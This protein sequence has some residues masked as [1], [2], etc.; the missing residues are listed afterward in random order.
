[1]K[2]SIKIFLFFISVTVLSSCKKYLDLAPISSQA[3][4]N[5][6]K[7]ESDIDQALAGVY[8]VLLT[9]PDVDN[10]YLSECRSSN[11]YIYSVD[12]ARDYYTLAHFQTTSSLDALETSWTMNYRLIERA[13]HILDVID[14][15]SFADTTK[16]SREKAET[17]F[18]RA[19]A[20][21][22]LVKIF[23]PVPLIKTV[24]S[25]T[26]AM[27]YPRVGTDT[28]Y[29]FITS[30]LQAVANTTALPYKYTTAAL[31]GRVNRLAAL[32]L[33]GK[34]YMFMAGYPLQKTANYQNAQT[35]LKQVLDLE[36]TYWNFAPTYGEIFKT[37][38]DNK[39]N[40][41]EVQYISGGK[42]LGSVI[43]GEVVP[44]DMTTSL[45][46]FGYY[47]MAGLTSPSRDL[48]KSYEPGDKRE[49]LTIDT[50]YR[51]KANV[52]VQQDWVRKYLDS[53]VASSISNSSDWPI[54]FPLL[55]TED[56]MLLYAES[57]NEIGGPTA[58]TVAIVNRLRTRAGLAGI[59]P[60]TQAGFRTAIMNERRHEL[61]WEGQ[62]WFDLVRTNTF[63]PV[64]NSFLTAYYPT[65]S[66]AVVQTQYLLP[67]P[68]TEM[69]V[70]PG[71]Y[72]QNAGY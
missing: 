39:Y 37:V 30:E 11:F 62:Y 35:V 54:N 26:D 18:L 38:N 22:D 59:N 23:G 14:N 71:L 15:I 31:T 58:A 8:N 42:G 29:N 25:S 47:Y 24:V 4:T 53:S 55:R 69:N 32:G 70:S 72:Y 44:I 45:L 19:Y 28:I 9:Y 61:A 34:A 52:W 68:L 7:S 43:P 66:T 67:V 21:F 63:L 6:F 17:R 46:P 56:V 50:L 5:F 1:M 16:R 3:N 40:L 51:N 20:Y 10:Y 41:F 57:T 12:A 2:L 60:A 36:T 49:F 64:M 27:K 48:I 33:L 13:N 65:N